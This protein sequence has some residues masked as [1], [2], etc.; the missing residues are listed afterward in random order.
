MP[1]SA[2]AD[3]LAYAEVGA[4]AKGRVHAAGLAYTEVLAQA[5]LYDRLGSANR[6][7]A[8]CSLLVRYCR[9]KWAG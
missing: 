9:P 8:Y 4:H 7:R 3:G 2:H 5:G 6:R 1:I